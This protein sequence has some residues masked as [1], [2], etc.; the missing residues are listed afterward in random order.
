[1][2]QE[3]KSRNEMDKRYQW[4]LEDIFPT[5]VAYEQ[6]YAQAEKSIESMAAW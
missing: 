3:L 5:D 1:M 4:R 2:A 6:A